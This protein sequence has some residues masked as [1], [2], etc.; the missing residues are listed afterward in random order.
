MTNVWGNLRA[1]LLII[2]H[3]TRFFQSITFQVLICLFIERFF[4]WLQVDSF[5]IDQESIEIPESCSD[6]CENEESEGENINYEDEDGDESEGSGESGE[7]SGDDAETDQTPQDTK[8]RL[9]A[10][11]EAADEAAQAL[12]R[13]RGDSR[14][15]KK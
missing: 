12:T 5:P 7:D 11:L 8:A 9:E 13:M 15:N 4:L 6:S 3:F 2:I 14:D 10:L 1:F